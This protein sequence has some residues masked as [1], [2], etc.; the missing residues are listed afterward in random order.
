MDCMVITLLVQVAASDDHSPTNNHNDT[1]PSVGRI[2]GPR[3]LG[4]ESKQKKDEAEVIRV[5]D[6]IMKVGRR[7]H[8]A[9]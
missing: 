6:D 3:V 8:A 4:I 1:D 5:G 9:V 7:Y 2:G